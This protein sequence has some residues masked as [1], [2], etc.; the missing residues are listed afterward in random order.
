MQLDSDATIRQRIC[1]LQD[2]MGAVSARA[3]A[4]EAIARGFW[5]EDRLANTAIAWATKRVRQVITSDDPETGVQRS[6][7]ITKD[8]NPTFQQIPLLDVDQ[9][10]FVL[11]EH[12][13]AISAD[14]MRVRSLYEFFVLKFG[15]DAIAP[16][17]EMR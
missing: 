13:S 12:L 7:A 10:N 14:L 6:A 9:A 11:Q 4:K 1:D 2:E 8:S 3:I 5:E 16:I 17:P 15:A